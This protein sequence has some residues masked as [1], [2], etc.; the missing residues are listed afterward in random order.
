MRSPLILRLQPPQSA[1]SS[2]HRTC[3]CDTIHHDGFLHIQRGRIPPLLLEQMFNT[4]FTDL[5]HLI[6]VS[7]PI[8]TPRLIQFQSLLLQ[9]SFARTLVTCSN[10]LHWYTKGVRQSIFAEVDILLL[11]DPPLRTRLIFPQVP[12]IECSVKFSIQK[13]PRKSPWR[14][15][16][17]PD[18]NF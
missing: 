18:G 2:S 11:P 9:A 13:A 17:I 16:S 10:E 14:L 6:F 1:L 4:L 3:T 12:L 8:P 15:V 7:L 5:V